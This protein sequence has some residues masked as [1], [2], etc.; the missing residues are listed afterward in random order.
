M[1]Q[2]G[3][4]NQQFPTHNYQNRFHQ[5]GGFAGRGRGGGAFGGSSGGGPSNPQVQTDDAPFPQDSEHDGRRPSQAGTDSAEAGAERRNS[6]SV[7][8]VTQTPADQT[9]ALDH[10]PG[11]VNDETNE[12][13]QEGEE[14][15]QS[16]ENDDGMH[17]EEGNSMNA[18][19]EGELLADDHEVQTLIQSG[20][21]DMDPNAF[22]PAMMGMG[23]LNPAMTPMMPFG[24]QNGFFAPQNNFGGGFG[25]RGRGG[26]RGGYRGRGGF[27]N[28]HGGFNGHMNQPSE[29]FTVVAGPAEGPPIDA[30]KGPKAMR[31]G[32]PNS[33]IY[34][35]GGFQGGRNAAQHEPTPQPQSLPAQSPPPQRE[36]SQS[37]ARDNKER[38]RS[39]SRSRSASQSRKRKHSVD[40]QGSE[41]RDRRRE[42][43]RR[44][45]RKYD[46][47]I[48]D[49]ERKETTRSDSGDE[50][51]SRRSRRRR[52]RE[53]HRS[54]RSHRDTSRDAH[55][56][57]HRSR[58]RGDDKY[59]NDNDELAS[60]SGRRA[61]S[62]RDRDRDR[63]RERDRDRGDRDR[64]R[65]RRDRSTS[66][67]RSRRDDPAPADDQGFKIKG[68][69]TKFAPPT[70]PRKDRETR[71]PR[72]PS[73]QSVAVASLVQDAA[74]ADPYAVEREA[75]IKERMAKEQ[76]RRESATLGKRGRGEEGG[77]RGSNA[78]FADAPT[79]PKAGRKSRKVSYRYEDEEGEEARAERVERE[80]EA[81]RWG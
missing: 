77:R 39:A 70:G 23:G 52:D 22:N 11:S 59:R 54:S 7:A 67:R 25:G 19:N 56:R 6:Q 27:N 30:P 65:S 48:V 47:E 26:F 31:E 18:N 45:E 3:Y 12:Q 72:R 66:A 9:P 16:L 69:R 41:A 14:A 78:G 61:K 8:S 80:R 62:R 43:R 57:R 49:T 35:R 75:R 5:R 46:D 34:S 1:H 73:L 76:Q 2:G 40:S 68:S 15:G 71:S 58:S 17:M 13:V 42:R 55:H 51:S 38:G 28:M 32:L 74:A 64:K 53:K 63:E 29:N 24:N 4:A 37:P 60:D 81:G 79:G 50:D 36:R 44:H 21:H 33:G 20:V 10:Q